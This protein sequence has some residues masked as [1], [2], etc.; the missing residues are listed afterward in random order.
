MTLSKEQRGRLRGA[1]YS[2]DGVRA[3]R[4][5]AEDGLSDDALQLS[6][7]GL[8]AAL[9][10]GV[11]G[12]APLARRVAAALRDRAWDGDEELGDQLEAALGVRPIPLLRPLPVDLD[13]FSDALEGDP[14]QGG[15]RV[16]LTTGEIW[17]TLSLD[18]AVETGEEDEEDLDDP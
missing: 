5:I 10:Q 17:N 13:E 15:G 12:G 8:L 11:D 3:V 4:A 2:G 16:D 7:D 6:G 1:A 9:D 18:Y 14:A